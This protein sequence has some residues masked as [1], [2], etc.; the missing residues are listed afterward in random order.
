MSKSHHFPFY[1]LSKYSTLRPLLPITIVNPEN[2]L[3]DFTWA[4]IDT[5]ADRCVFPEYIAKHLYHDMKHKKAKTD[6]VNTVGS[7]IKVY[8]HTFGIKVH[9][10]TGSKNNPKI[11]N[12]IID[13]PKILV[14]VVPS[15]AENESGE[16]IHTSFN[17]VLLGVSDFMCNYILNIDY[18][19]KRFSLRVP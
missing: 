3:E 12:P 7:C 14:D 2:G 4:I 16:A 13:I 6:Y 17:N 8:K 18:P 19:K 9:S 10:I 1:Q 11:G 15:I 5:G